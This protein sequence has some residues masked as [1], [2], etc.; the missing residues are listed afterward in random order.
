[1]T[2]GAKDMSSMCG[3]AGL[4]NI[5]FQNL[6]GKIPQTAGPVSGFHTVGLCF[7]DSFIH[8]R[9]KPL[10]VQFDILRNKSTLVENRTKKIG[11]DPAIAAPE[12]ANRDLFRITETAPRVVRIFRS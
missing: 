6:L 7:Q 1:M 4:D 10:A 12:L 2:N 11:H 3:N 8:P 9:S 5:T